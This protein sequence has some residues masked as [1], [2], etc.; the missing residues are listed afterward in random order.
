MGAKDFDFQ[1]YEKRPEDRVCKV[2]QIRSRYC[3]WWWW[4]LLC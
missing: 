2:A 3:W 1:L 4:A